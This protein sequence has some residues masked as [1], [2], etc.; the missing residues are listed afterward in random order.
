[1]GAT[2]ATG[3]SG[4]PFGN[5]KMQP[6]TFGHCSIEDDNTKEESEDPLHD[7]VHDVNMEQKMG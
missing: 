1:M 4:S 7:P 2:P 6:F 3:M 5:S